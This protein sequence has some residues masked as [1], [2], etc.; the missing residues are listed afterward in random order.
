MDVRLTEQVLFQTPSF[1]QMFWPTIIHHARI[2]SISYVD[3]AGLSPVCVFQCGWYWGPLSWDD[4]ESRLANKP[5]GSFLVRDS[6][7]DRYILSLSFRSQG[8]THHT[9]IEHYKGE[10]S[11]PPFRI[12]TEQF[13]HLKY[14]TLSSSTSPKPPLLHSTFCICGKVSLAKRLNG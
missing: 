2:S 13:V 12:I 7:D 6:S 11:L 3:V 9:R 1:V 8:T 5:D 14:E 4:A 10:Y